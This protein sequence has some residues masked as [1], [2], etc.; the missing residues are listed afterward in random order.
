MK[1]KC[2][3]GGSFVGTKSVHKEVRQESEISF[4]KPLEQPSSQLG[5]SNEFFFKDEGWRRESVFTVA[6]AEIALKAPQTGV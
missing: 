4:P 3:S 2:D 1:R 6:A 5:K